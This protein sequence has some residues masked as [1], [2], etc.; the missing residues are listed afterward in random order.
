MKISSCGKLAPLP[1]LLFL[2]VFFIVFNL[3]CASSPVKDYRL[4]AQGGFVPSRVMIVNGVKVTAV[5]L[6]E[7]GLLE[8]LQE[9]G[10]ERSFNTLNELPLDY[11]IVKITNGSERPVDFDPHETNLF[12]G[13]KNNLSPFDFSDLYRILP[14]RSDRKTVLQDLQALTLNRVRRLRPTETLTG[15]YLFRRPEAMGK[16]VALALDGFYLDGE[17]MS[18]TLTFN[19]ISPEV[20]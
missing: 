5:Y 19:A 11:F 15:M 20:K 13:G 9:R 7:S 18:V 10:L 2:G 17:P 14:P 12:D 6:D 3:S 8:T 4:V 1:G 16:N